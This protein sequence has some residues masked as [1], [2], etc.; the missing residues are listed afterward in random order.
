MVPAL[1]WRHLG[2]WTLQVWEQRSSYGAAPPHPPAA[3]CWG[4]TSGIPPWLQQL[5]LP[6]WVSHGVLTKHLRNNP[7][8]TTKCLFS[9]RFILAQN[10]RRRKKIL[11]RTGTVRAQ[12]VFP[13]CWKWAQWSL[14]GSSWGSSALLFARDCFRPL[15]ATQLPSLLLHAPVCSSSLQCPGPWCGGA[16]SLTVPPGPGPGPGH[17]PWS[18]ATQ[19]LSSATA[20]PPHPPGHTKSLCLQL[21]AFKLPRFSTC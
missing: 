3:G 6:A 7:T 14:A 4:V 9:G 21:S 8:T 13:D 10:Q 17:V 19:Q 2:L 18:L 20:H 5:H 12:I 1:C 11:P 16:R 15:P